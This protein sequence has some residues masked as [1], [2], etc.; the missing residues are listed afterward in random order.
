M[1]AFSIC[2]PEDLFTLI[3]LQLGQV[4][5]ADRQIGV[6]QRHVESTGSLTEASASVGVCRHVDRRK[7]FEARIL[8]RQLPDV[9]KLVVV[10]VVVVIVVV[11][12][13]FILGSCVCFNERAEVLKSPLASVTQR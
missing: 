8:L 2:P 3:L 1:K 9:E 11:V 6:L 5:Q 4:H 12:V 13:G 10:V 7:R